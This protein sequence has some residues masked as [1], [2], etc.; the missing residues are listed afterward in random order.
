LQYTSHFISIFIYLTSFQI[1][2]NIF[3]LTNSVVDCSEN[4]TLDDFDAA[5][6]T[7]LSYS[8]R[9]D[10]PVRTRHDSYFAQSPGFRSLS[11]SSPLSEAFGDNRKIASVVIA[12]NLDQAPRT[13]QI[14]ALELIRTKRLFTHTSVQYVPKRFL[15]IAVVAGGEGPRLTEHLNNHIFISH[16]HDPKDGYPN[17]EELDSDA[18]S[19]SSV[20]RKPANLEPSSDPVF[21]TADISAIQSLT[22][23]ISVSA[24][25]T[26]YIMNIIAFLR[27]HRGVLGGISPLATSHCSKLVRSLAPLHGLSYVTP[28]LVALAVKKI[29][30]HRIH[31]VPPEKE[32]SVQWGSN[33]D[34]VAAALEGMGAEAV[35]EDVLASVEVPV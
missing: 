7:E 14:Q 34:A 32:R 33:I 15:F 23:S 17:L 6:L 11:H 29:Y 22:S 30:P 35:I 10:P 9:D 18:E 16:F 20:V 31:I 21:S 25:I 24:E 4:T 19:I 28:S 5:L 8:P 26:R 2:S 3:G 27:L 13:V 12:K 1:A